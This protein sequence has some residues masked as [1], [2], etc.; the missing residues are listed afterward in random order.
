MD[1]DSSLKISKKSFISSVIILFILIILAGVLTYIIPSGNYVRMGVMGEEYIVP[2][3]FHFAEKT[4]Y[5]VWRWFTAPFETLWGPDSITVIFIILFICIIG[6]TFTLLDKSG[7]LKYIMNSLVKRFESSKYLLMGILVL[8]FMLFGSV[9][10]IFE[11]LIA[12]VPIVI[13]LSYALGWDSLTGLGMSALAAGFGFSAATLNPFTLGVA[14]ELAG[15]P[16]FSGVG[17]RIISFIIC[18]AVLYL[19]LYKYAKKIEKNPEKS[20]VYK[21]LYKKSLI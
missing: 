6:G 11:E 10:G 18:Y 16:A 15:V 14:Q 20:S 4:D 21:E 12:L 13:I 9:F 5:P 17:L 1:K 19:F 3:T 2:E 7:M 8:F